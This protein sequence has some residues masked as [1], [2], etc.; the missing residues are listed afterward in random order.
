MDVAADMEREIALRAEADHRVRINVCLHLDGAIVRPVQSGRE[1]DRGFGRGG[2]RGVER[3]PDREPDR[4]IEREIV[5][6][7]ILDVGS[8][9]PAQDMDG[10]C[11]TAE[12]L[13][14]PRHD[15][16]SPRSYVRIGNSH[17]ISAE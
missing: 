9:A 10:V 1:G 17:M 6:G 4:E 16:K 3:E 14:F 13:G 7:P 12:G 15:D 11:A 8:W 5:G 2:D